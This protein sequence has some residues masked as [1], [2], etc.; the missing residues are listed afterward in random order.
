MERPLAVVG[1]KNS[2]GVVAAVN[3]PVITGHMTDLHRL[4]TAGAVMSG[5]ETSLPVTREAASVGRMCV[6]EAC[7]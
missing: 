2:V 1:M 7:G 5:G 6:S 3:L 4:I